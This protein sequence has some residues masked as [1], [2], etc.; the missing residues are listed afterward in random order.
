M[1]NDSQINNLEMQLNHHGDLYYHTTNVSV[2]ERSNGYCQG[3]GFVLEQI[4][5]HVEW[6]KGIATVVKND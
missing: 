4:G 1:L 3:V 5:Y 6:H 2:H